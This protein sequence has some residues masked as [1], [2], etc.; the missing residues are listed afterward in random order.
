MRNKTS[1]SNEHRRLSELGDKGELL[2]RQYL[3]RKAYSFIT[4]QYHSRY[5]EL[6]LV[7][8]DGK[9][10]VF[11]EVK[12]R[13]TQTYGRG[14]ESVTKWKARKLMGTINAYLRK[15]SLHDTFWR[16]DIVSIE[17]QDEDWV[18]YHFEDAVR[19]VGGRNYW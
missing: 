8:R 16:V 18:I 15:Y 11:V 4:S 2:A 12:L 14:E 9:E 5:G 3:E 13:K 19:D 17:K 10:L 1:M 7:M 6:D